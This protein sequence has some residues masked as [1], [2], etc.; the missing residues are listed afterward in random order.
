MQKLNK[1]NKILFTSL[2]CM[3][4]INAQ[5]QTELNFQ[6]LARINN[7]I[8]LASQ[9]ICMLFS[10]LPGSSTNVAEYVETRRVT[11]NAQ[12]IFTVC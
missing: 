2:I 1:L 12:G 4:I 9:P 8:I 11:T 7:N 3:V 6:G 5:A 10:I